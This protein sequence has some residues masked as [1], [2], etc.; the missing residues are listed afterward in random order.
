[1]FRLAAVLCLC[2]VV[3]RG[4]D[5]AWERLPPLPEARGV[6]AP[7]A[8]VHGGALI[9]A[10]GANFPDRLPW[11]GGAKVWHDRVWVLEKPEGQW[12]DAGR[13]PR[14][15]AHGVSV[16]TPDG[17]ICVGGSDATAHYSDVFRL[18]LKQGALQTQRLPPLP[19]A[20]ANACGA[21]AGETLCVGTGSE[22]PGEKSAT[23]RAFA[24]DLS[25]QPPAWSELPPLPGR[26]RLLATAAAHDGRW[27]LLG[28]AA[29]EP[30]AGGKAKRAYLRE[31]WSYQ[32]DR[33]WRRLADLPRPSVAAPSPAP[34]VNDALLLVSGDDGT[35]A[36]FTPPEKHPG[37]PR[38]ILAYDPARDAWREA[39]TTPAPRVTV[40]CVEWQGRLILP[41]GEVRPG[42]RSPEVWSFFPRHP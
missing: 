29:L 36:G 2:A 20:L 23:S 10:G 33:G 34:W 35:L 14:P 1:M 21:L 38:T 16:S 7:F 8:G 12:R 28:G 37:F 6:A 15:L 32:A 24:L 22:T 3:A 39:G 30:T 13:L 11:E 40:P 42:V 4:D 25:A 9:V 19:I 27:F 17:V 31:A 26:A 41:S 5:L 18:S